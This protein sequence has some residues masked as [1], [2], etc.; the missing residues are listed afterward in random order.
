LLLFDDLL[1]LF[2]DGGIHRHRLGPRRGRRT[3][4]GRKGHTKGEA[5]VPA[6]VRGCSSELHIDGPPDCRYGM[7]QEQRPSMIFQDSVV[8]KGLLFS[9]W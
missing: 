1:E 2:E 5:A 8:M 7:L 4:P 6:V 9:A 3:N